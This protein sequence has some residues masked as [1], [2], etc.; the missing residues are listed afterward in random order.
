MVLIFNPNWFCRIF[1]PNEKRRKRP[2]S[3]ALVELAPRSCKCEV[4]LW[5]FFFWSVLRGILNW[6]CP[7]CRVVLGHSKDS[8]P[9]LGDLSSTED[10]WTNRIPLRILP[11]SNRADQHLHAK[12][13]AIV[14]EGESFHYTVPGIHSSLL[15]KSFSSNRCVLLRWWS[16]RSSLSDSSG[17]LKT[18]TAW[19]VKSQ[20]QMYGYSVA[21]V[22]WS[23]DLSIPHCVNRVRR[24]CPTF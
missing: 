10:V 1:D 7:S 23:N 19:W 24:I 4:M 14:P 9:L 20:R 21:M 3:Y 22:R 13:G 6:T 15:R 2:R 16:L 8:W 11:A 5:I 18:C 12:S 17:F